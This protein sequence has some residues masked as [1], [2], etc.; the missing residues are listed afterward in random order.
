MRG[1]VVERPPVRALHVL[2]RHPVRLG[3]NVH[4]HLGAGAW[5]NILGWKNFLRLS[6]L[7]RVKTS[8]TEFP[9]PFPFSSYRQRKQGV[10]L[11]HISGGRETNGF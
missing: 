6:L 3:V 9:L 4:Q 11:Q 8:V 5:K 7:F 2:L 1:R 10:N